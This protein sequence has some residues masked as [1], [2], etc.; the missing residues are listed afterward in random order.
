LFNVDK[1]YQ[2]CNFLKVI[3]STWKGPYVNRSALNRVEILESKFS[4]SGITKT[5]KYLSHAT[6]GYLWARSCDV[7]SAHLG[8]TVYIHDGRNVIQRNINLEMVG[9]KFGVFA[10][11]RKL[12]PAFG[13]YT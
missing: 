11:T 4:R 3:R 7:T 5:A 6:S 13:V 10:L 9:T 1:C 8:T 2:N 12:K